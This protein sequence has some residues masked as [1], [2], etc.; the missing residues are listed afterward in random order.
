MKL[1]LKEISLNGISHRT[2]G[3]R[4]ISVVPTL[5]GCLFFALNLFGSLSEVVAAEMKGLYDVQVIVN[6]Q[7]FDERRSASQD[8]LA[9]I[10][11]RIAGQSSVL[12]EKEIQAMLMDPEQF[13]N[14]FAY[15]SSSQ[16][17]Y[18]EGNNPVT[19]LQL[20]LSFDESAIKLRLKNNRF[21]IWG[22]NRPQV[23]V[24]WATEH[25]GERTL[26]NFE[27]L[28]EVA[29]QIFNNGVRR[30]LPLDFPLL[31]IQDSVSVSVRDV[32]GFFKQPIVAA[33][34][35]YGA[36]AVLMGRN[37]QTSE[38]QWRGTWILQVGAEEFWYEGDGTDAAEI[39]SQAMD[40]TADALGQLYAIR[41]GEGDAPKLRMV[42]TGVNQLEDYAELQ[43]YLAEL[44]AVRSARLRNVAGETLAYDL[45]LD[46]D[47]LQLKQIIRLDHKLTLQK[48]DYLWV[49]DTPLL[50]Y[51]W[52]GL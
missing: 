11:V 40:F 29:Q 43:R 18:D 24:W 33:S 1:C 37:W 13:V 28:P 46:A 42:V 4:R 38:D 5:W 2:N 22:D 23:L 41:G 10:I 47:L 48:D 52:N 30:G 25:Q 34:Q 21:P 8:A 26:V 31:D 32:W 3:C 27:Q 17:E 7:Q 49:D 12:Q 15:H 45:E 6:S 39:F 9:E 19:R 36:E 16:P 44:S 20:M 50:E 51:R 14:S 35:R